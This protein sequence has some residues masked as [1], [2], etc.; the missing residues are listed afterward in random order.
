MRYAKAIVAVGTA[1]LIAI[2]N[3]IPMSDTARGWVTVLL[4]ALGAFAVYQVP[5]TP[6]PTTAD[7][8]LMGR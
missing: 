5:N 8:T 3:A 6:M 2:Q 7:K 4:A 1:A